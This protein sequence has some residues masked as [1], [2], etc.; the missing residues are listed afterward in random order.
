MSSPG[1]EIAG[2]YRLEELLG[3]GEGA[4]VWRAHDQELGRT[5]A[6]KLL[7][8]T[9]DPERFRREA[10]AVAS[11]AH[12]NVMQLFDY[13]EVD[14]RPFMVLE[15]LPGGTLAERLAP[16][17][18]L[19]VEAIEPIA[20]G[21]AAGL[22]HA[23]ERGIVHRDLKPANILF[24][25]DGR[26]KIADFGIARR[27][28]GEGTLTEAGTVLGTANYI[29][30]EQAAGEPAGPASD[31][32]A[33]GVILFHLLTGR[34][35][36][37]SGD[38]LELAALHRDA[39]PPPMAPVAADVPPA[40]VALTEQMLAKDP[41]QRPADG[42][43]AYAALA[44]TPVAA[45]EATN[46]TRVLPAVPPPAA[47]ERSR[48]RT[49]V[50]AVVLVALALAGAGLAWAVTRP[51]GVSGP[52]LGTT[53]AKAQTSTRRST[54]RSNST[55]T[56]VTTPIVATTTSPTTT[57]TPTTRPATTQRRTTTQATTTTPPLPTT[58]VEITTDTTDTTDTTQTTTDTTTTP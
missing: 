53:D 5:V 54:T 22:A 42:A 49:G 46:V 4:E 35:P 37:V 28:A 6:V 16:G 23:H 27:A 29:S 8:P 56:P 15:Y 10:Q 38:A 3:G 41:A 25:E 51:S 24:D 12:Q 45:A 1:D 48:A 52:P 13:G 55:A 18:P 32:Y 19:P 43:A 57:T 40:L 14:G 21:V 26:P 11:L 31:V 44:A 30:P 36:F 20:L 9:A 7:A 17:E 47:A 50:V 39:P 58:T 2:R 33:L 34:L